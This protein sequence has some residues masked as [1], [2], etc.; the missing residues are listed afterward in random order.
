MINFSLNYAPYCSGH[1]FLEF[2]ESFRFRRYAPGEYH[3]PHLDTYTFEGRTLILTALLYLTDTEAG[4][5]THFPK[6]RPAPVAVRPRR[7]RLALWFNHRPDGAVDPAALHEALPVRRGVKATVAN[8]L[9][10]TLDRRAT[11]VV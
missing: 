7:G 2:G 8:F 9:Y 3:P 1:L 6:A 4:G 11:E 5:E 10:Q